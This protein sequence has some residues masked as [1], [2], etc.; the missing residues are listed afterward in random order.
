M[1]K[2]VDQN[3]YPTSYVVGPLNT[4]FDSIEAQIEKSRTLLARMEARHGALDRT[5]AVT[6]LIEG[7][8]ITSPA[9]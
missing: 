7:K 9:A 3:T 6:P 4:T 1:R 5:P 2:P 8:S